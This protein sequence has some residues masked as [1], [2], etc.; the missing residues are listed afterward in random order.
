MAYKRQRRGERI[1]W[2]LF[3][4]KIMV[5]REG[6]GHWAPCGGGGEAEGG[7]QRVMWGRM[8]AGNGLGWGGG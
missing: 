7:R 1:F 8:R 4:I 6:N 5:N 3:W 2:G